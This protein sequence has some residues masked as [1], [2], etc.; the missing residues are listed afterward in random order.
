MVIQH[1]RGTSLE[2]AVITADV[3]CD[4]NDINRLGRQQSTGLIS[5]RPGFFPRQ[6]AAKLE[7]V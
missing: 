6:G 4:P 3:P 5:N 7:S 2:R 1:A